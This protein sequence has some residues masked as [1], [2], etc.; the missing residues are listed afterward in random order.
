M[1]HEMSPRSTAVLTFLGGAAIGAILVALTTPKRGSELCDDLRSLGRRLRGKA[2][3]LLDEAEDTWDDLK[4][5][6]VDE[7]KSASRKVRSK[8][9]EMASGREDGRR[10]GS[11]EELS[12]AV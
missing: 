2:S 5:E 12:G 6:A 11:D 10:S 7:V 4:D 8:A 3:A 1:S 9:R